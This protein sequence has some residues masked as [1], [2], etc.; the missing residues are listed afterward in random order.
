MR[1]SNC[2]LLQ[3]LSRSAKLSNVV[4]SAESCLPRS[5]R[6]AANAL[7]L[8]EVAASTKRYAAH[9]TLKSALPLLRASA[10]IAP[11]RMLAA[12]DFAVLY[13]FLTEN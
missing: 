6:I 11:N 10:A 4:K 5:R 13:Y 2:R 12:G 1:L 9:S 3:K 7:R 8:G